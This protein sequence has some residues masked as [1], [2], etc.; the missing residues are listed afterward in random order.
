MHP[1]LKYASLNLI[2]NLKIKYKLTLLFLILLLPLIGFVYNS[3]KSE[4]EERKDLKT[5]YF[6]LEENRLISN[7]IFEYQSERALVTGF[8]SSKGL[9]FGSRLNNQRQI[10]DKAFSEIEKHLSE[11]GEKISEIEKFKELD[12]FR[13][14]IDELQFSKEEFNNF[15]NSFLDGLTNRIKIN[16]KNVTDP[17]IKDQLEAQIKLVE[18]K[19]YLGRIRTLFNKISTLNNISIKDYDLL[20]D[21]ST[22]YFMY[23]EDFLALSPDKVLSYY[24][25]RLTN[26]DLLDVNNLLVNIKEDSLINFSKT[27]P[28]NWFNKFSLA[29]EVLRE[30]EIYSFNSVKAE[31][32]S[33]IKK[34]ERTLMFF[35]SIVLLSTTL[36]IFFAAYTI[37]FIIN[38]V[39]GLSS[40]AEK[41]ALGASDVNVPVNSRDEFGLLASSFSKLAKRS[42]ELSIVAEAVG[43]GNYNIDL[44]VKSEYDVLG[45]ALLKMKENLKKLSQEN[46]NR[47]WVISGI[48]HINDMMT[49]ANNPEFMSKKV[50]DYLCSYTKSEAGI[51]FILDPSQKFSFAAGFGITNKSDFSKPVKPGEGIIG[52]AILQKKT[53]VIKDIDGKFLKIKSAL[54]DIDAVNILIAPLVF[55][56]IVTG[57]I[58]LASRNKFTDLDIELIN[59]TAERIAIVIASIKSNL[60]TQELLNETQNQAEELETQQ[61]EMRQINDEL[62]KQ[63][64]YLQSSEEELKVSQ[65]ELREKND[66]LELKTHELEEQNKILDEARQAIELKVLQVESIS[67]Y[68]TEFLANMSHELRTPLNSI[69]ILSK[70]LMDETLKHGMEKQSE[71]AKVIHNSGVDLLKLVNEILDLSKIESRQINLDIREIFVNDIVK[72]RELKHIAKEKEIDFISEIRPGT[73]EKIHTDEFRL[74]QILKNLLS[75]AFKFTPKKGSVSLIVFPAEKN[76]NFRSHALKESNEIIAFEVKDTGIGIPKDLQE[77]VFDAFKQGDSSTTRKFGGTGLGLSISKNLAEILGGEIHLESKEHQGSTFTLYL[78]IWYSG[79]ENIQL[80]EKNLPEEIKKI[81]VPKQVLRDK[82]TILIIEDDKSFNQILADF[83]KNKD[84]DVLQAFTG[85][86][87]LKMI[88]EKPDAV[89]LDLH[90]PDMSGWEI[91]KKVREDTRFKYIQ[92]HIMSA[93]DID[94]KEHPGFDEYLP[95]PITLEKINQAFSSISYKENGIQRILIVED[96]KVENEAIA[97][98]L[99]SAKINTISAFSGQE[100][101]E[102]LEKNKVDAVILD[103]VLPDMEGYEV[104]ESIRMKKN[105]VGTPII[106]YSGKDLTLSEENKL[107]KYA[108]TI[109]IKN[110]YSYQRLMEEVKLFLHMVHSNMEKVTQGAGLNLPTGILKN[111]KALIVDDD[112]RNVYSLFNILESEGMEVDVAND[113]KEA[114]LKLKEKSAPDIILMDIMMPEMDGIECIKEIR[115]NKEYWSLPVIALTAKAMKGDKEKCME[116]GASDYISKPVNLNKLLSLMRIWIYDRKIKHHSGRED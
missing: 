21:Y 11:T 39:S 45:N 16:S 3:V 94:S 100:A 7:L 114:L 64:E 15:S 104:M 50:I 6:N 24:K 62:K 115:K 58:E 47:N 68:K 91:L 85:K 19:Q 69:L 65:E 76:I 57:V 79:S 53:I 29:I 32:S 34:K 83:A 5:T 77:L 110:E 88:E 107:K 67:R 113:G 95:K 30:V 8:I 75:N 13:H 54:S 55:D 92:V 93:Y 70:L 48:S 73:P 12:D 111:K 80:K 46:E 78:P 103:L 90:L 60:Q 41:L 87:G 2:K 59:E 33:E 36:A 49:G 23:L 10:T 105:N 99:S 22:I 112:M 109:I 35:I 1:N 108:N 17:T 56:N 74:G 101:L 26:N 61:E 14:Q 31:M 71:H 72:L 37:R 43:K 82:K 20:G 98:L 51:V 63:T 96:N 44:P 116:A 27:D 4:F 42:N 106:I 102:K 18:S 28:V 97:Q 84:F 40:A 81:S 9:N 89:L 66:E 52:E 25:S 38:N 86:E